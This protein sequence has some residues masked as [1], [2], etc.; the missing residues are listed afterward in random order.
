M[1]TPQPNEEAQ[2]YSLKQLHQQYDEQLAQLSAVPYL[3][4]EEEI[5]E[6][7]LKKLKLQVKDQLYHMHS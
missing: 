2:L 6:T 3:S 7:R 1:D 4:A 5:E